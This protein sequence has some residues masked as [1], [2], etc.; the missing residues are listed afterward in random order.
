MSPRRKRSDRNAHPRARAFSLIEMLVVIGLIALIAGLAAPAFKTKS[1]SIDIAHRQ[2]MDDLNRARQ[3][4]ISTRSTVYVLFFPQIDPTTVATSLLQ[5]QRD[6]LAKKQMHGY[7]I[8][9]RRTVGGQPG[10]DE[11]RYLSEWKELPDGV[12]FHPRK[13][14]VSD[15]GFNGFLP[16]DFYEEVPANVALPPRFPVPVVGG[17]GHRRIFYMAYDSTGALT[18]LEDGDV[19]TKANRDKNKPDYRANLEL[20][21]TIPLLSGS[22][23]A[24]FGYDSNNRKAYTWAPGDP[25]IKAPSTNTYNLAD[26]V[27]WVRVDVLTG[28]S[29]V[30]GGEI[31]VR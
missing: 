5:S 20:R 16:L 1:L 28:R 6:L 17:I 22:I 29:R 9:S 12:I 7:A 2:L 26:C 15:L 14:D 21:A 3:L 18:L 25:I 13:F 4:A 24:P 11:P 31:T 10:A 27:K 30:E 8:F 19:R 23:G